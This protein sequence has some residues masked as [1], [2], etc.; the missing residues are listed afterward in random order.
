MAMDGKCGTFCRREGTAMKEP[1]TPEEIKVLHD[2]LRSDTERYLQIVNG[3][4]AE[5]TSIA[6]SPGCIWVNRGVQL[7]I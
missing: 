5:N 7:T 4:I 2:L 3:W 1:T 6:I